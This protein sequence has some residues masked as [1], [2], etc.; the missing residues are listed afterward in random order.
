MNATEKIASIEKKM[1]LFEPTSEQYKAYQEIIDYLKEVSPE[2]ESKIV[3]HKSAEPEL[4]E[5]CQ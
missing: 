1:R 3:V 2:T 5:S 4:C